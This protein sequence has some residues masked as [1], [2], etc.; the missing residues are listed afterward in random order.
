MIRT[1]IIL[2]WFLF[3]Y[4]VKAYTQSSRNDIAYV[5]YSSDR[6]DSTLVT[7]EKRSAIFKD[8]EAL[9]IRKMAGKTVL[10]Y[11]NQNKP[12]EAW[13]FPGT[14]N[15][16]ALIIGG[17]HGSELSS[18]EIALETA[19]MLNNGETPY[20]NVI[21]IPVLFPD[22]AAAALIPDGTL[23]KG[24]YTNN[25]LADP[26]RQMP[27]LG[28]A[29]DAAAALDHTGRMI[30]KENQLLLQLIQEYNPSRIVN[31]HAIRDVMK[32]GIYADPKTD[33]NSIALGFSEDSM[34]AISMAAYIFNQGGRVPGNQLDKTPNALYY[35]DPPIATA[36]ER[37]LRNLH[38]SA[39]P[40]NRG[41]GVSLGG[42]AATAVCDSFYSRN[43]IT[44]ITIEF[45]GYNTSSQ[46]PTLKS[47][48]DCR[49]NIRLYAKAITNI[50][51][52][53]KNNL[54]CLLRH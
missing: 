8:I 22:N 29:F 19:E 1:A 14:G 47:R 34:L 41:H 28:K 42:W 31:L 50:F 49:H 6:K 23:N 48:E 4:S 38:G 12:V 21:I 20:Y 39:M 36:G 16:N 30:E 32:A 52:E 53:Q 11:S 9:V 17:M 43:A 5:S 18:I 25:E 40:G 3:L 27:D 54:T 15:E 7:P 13:Y 37:Q 2:G 45:P 44:L 46:Y 26:N 24:R 51:L 10:G 33:C 35:N